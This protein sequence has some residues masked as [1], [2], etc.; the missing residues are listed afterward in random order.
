MKRQVVFFFSFALGTTPYIVYN[1][2]PSRLIPPPPSP[3]SP[4]SSIFP[5]S[6]NL[7][8]GTFFLFSFFGCRERRKGRKRERSVHSFVIHLEMVYTILPPSLL[9][10]VYMGKD[11]VF[12]PGYG[13]PRF[14]SA[15]AL[16]TPSIHPSHRLILWDQINAPPVH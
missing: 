4:V 6:E 3:P 5:C 2:K 12:V 9:S 15:P 13:L 11:E 10:S 8:I 16:F 7:D 1:A 14:R